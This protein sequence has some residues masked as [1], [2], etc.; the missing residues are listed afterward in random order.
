L[1]EDE[2]IIH[3]HG[4]TIIISEATTVEIT[5]VTFGGIGGLVASGTIMVGGDI[6][7][8]TLEKISTGELGMG[9]SPL[10]SVRPAT[11][12]Q[13]DPIITDLITIYDNR[14]NIYYNSCYK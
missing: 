6:K 10:L 7:K 9:I 5:L 11:L 13:V 12:G 1:D 14:R 4:D 3:L 2:I 8:Q